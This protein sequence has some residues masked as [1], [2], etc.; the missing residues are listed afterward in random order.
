MQANSLIPWRPSLW[1][2]QVRFLRGILPGF[3]RGWRVPLAA[4]QNHATW[5][6]SAWGGSHTFPRAKLGILGHI[7]KIEFHNETLVTAELECF[8]I[9]GT[10]NGPRCQRKGWVNRFCQWYSIIYEILPKYAP[11]LR[12]SS[13]IN[14]VIQTGKEKAKPVASLLPPD[15][16]AGIGHRKEFP[17]GAV[18]G[19]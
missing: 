5:V 8:I 13:E 10:L 14:V 4:S 1:W 19:H 17:L 2:E 15:G 11:L 12:L 6:S 18:S 16:G 7:T 3:G 9:T